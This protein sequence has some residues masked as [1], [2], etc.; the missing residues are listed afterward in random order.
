MPPIVTG[1]LPTV[2]TPAQMSS[3][4]QRPAASSD[5]WQL[6]PPI[7]TGKTPAVRPSTPPRSGQLLPPIVTGA[8]P[9]TTPVVRP[10]TPPRTEPT[11]AASAPLNQL[12][13]QGTRPAAP[14]PRSLDRN[15]DSMKPFD[16]WSQPGHAEEEVRSAGQRRSQ[17]PA[18]PQAPLLMDNPDLAS[19]GVEPVQPLSSSTNNRRSKKRAR[20]VNVKRRYVVAALA[21][22]GVVAAGGLAA[23][24]AKTIEHMAMGL[25][26]K[27]QTAQQQGGAATANGAKQQNT[28]M[29]QAA[30]TNA[31]AAGH[32]GTVI[33]S[34]NMPVNSAMDFTNPTDKKPSMLIRLPNGNFV[35]YEKACTHEG[36]IIHYDTGTHTMVCP[37]HGA[38]FDPAKNGAVLQGPATTPVAK[39]NV[40]INADGTITTA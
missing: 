7:V 8:T 11:R 29:P 30:K 2:N 32:T 24:N 4:P 23:V 16:W 18:Q 22:G 9:A 34:S 37:A 36:V 38:I 33:G 1:H 3:S 13:Q 39:V 15:T 40:R 26:S 35:A 27:M 28:A 5:T 31:P 10:S 21:T 20:G 14:E 25:M 17:E 12:P 6:L 19:W